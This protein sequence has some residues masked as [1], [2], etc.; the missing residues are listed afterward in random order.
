MTTLKKYNSAII[1]PLKENFSNK[2][3]GAVSIWVNEYQKYTK[4]KKDLV[5]CKKLPKSFKYL[6]KDVFP[7]NVKHNL[8]TNL[9]YIKSIS[10]QIKA[11]DIFNIEIH[12]RPEYA[13]Y[14]IKHN[15]KV[16]INLIFHNNPNT[17]RYSNTANYKKFLLENCN[18]IIF[19]S[20]WVRKK[21]FENLDID[22]KNN[23]EVIYN[24]INPI[25]EFP[26]KN[27]TII[28]S[29]KLNKSK[30]YNIFG[31]TIIK[32]LK[33]YPEWN[34]VVYGNE[35]RETFNFNHP[36]LKI[37]NWVDHNKLLKIYEQASISVVNPTWDEPFGRTALESAS[38]GCAVITS[39]SGGLSETF[40]NNLVLNNN[41]NKSLFNLISKLID[42]KK[43][44]LK[45][46][47]ENF[48]NLIHT[49][50]I[51]IK[52][53]DFLR[54]IDSNF[55]Y[56]K[57]NFLK[58]LHISNFG[59]KNNHR[60]FNLSIAKKLSNG[61][62]RNGHDVIDFDY[63]N[64]GNKLF[65]NTS[66]DNK[67]KLIVANYKPDL[68]LLGHNN[69]L[70][71]NTLLFI[72]EKFNCKI[73]LWYEDH[74]MMGDPNYRTNLNLIEKNH[75]LID[76]FFITTSP[77]IINT[78][79]PKD[80]LNFLPIPADPNIENGEFYKSDKTKDLFFALSHGVNFGK[81]K[82]NTKDNRLNFIEELMSAS[83]ENFNYHFLGLFDEQPKWNYDFN[84]ELMISK[85]ALNLSRGGPSKYSSSNR[86][87]TIMGNGILPF[88]HEKVKY[89][90]FF[91]N[92]EIIIYKNSSDLLSKLS[93]INTNENMIIK[94]S[95]K[96][97]KQ[98]FNIFSNSIVA[99][100]II[101]KIFQFKKNYKYI[102]D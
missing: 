29:G 91:D 26:N 9:Q 19:V 95:K 21:F 10:L 99:D 77:D 32:I 28:F 49:P 76:E 30:G 73:A 45:K 47:K 63:R 54:N 39:K 70:N 13:F 100:F 48:N 25:K 20:N 52:K 62:T 24:F 66:I 69:S 90:D 75:N 46:Q 14:L 6:N 85:T 41:N 60:L 88:I 33:K 96:A 79:I 23:T 82:K 16:K 11:R 83:K 93:S 44:L 97:K 22:H 37:N 86:I 59:V 78:S 94:R 5:F 4:K 7:I 64:F 42:N 57:N 87:A 72:K 56:E 80:K 15:P 1:L 67:I 98:Y 8:Y 43:Y 35:E 2:D 74:V 68:V 101:Y 12:N 102:W 55:F 53:L 61:F 50:D 3:F 84:N 71:R 36:R 65:S 38:R 34:A 18:K 58:I 89:Q 81:L 51:S 27:K 40:N 17:I 31:E 92:D